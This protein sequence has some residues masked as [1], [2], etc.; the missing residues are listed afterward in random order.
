M[1]PRIFFLLTLCLLFIS[2]ESGIELA[3]DYLL[4]I[5]DSP[6]I[7]LSYGANIVPPEVLAYSVQN[8]YILAKRRRWD[9]RPIIIDYF[10]VKIL[11]PPVRWQKDITIGYLTKNEFDS[12]TKQL[13]IDHIEWK[14]VGDL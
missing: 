8:K 11:P 5:E 2:C 7:N 14:E 4:W 10:V 12:L 1:K 9:T 13:G 6:T 3:P